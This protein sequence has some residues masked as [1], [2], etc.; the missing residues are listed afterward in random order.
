MECV[1]YEQGKKDIHGNPLKGIGIAVPKA[2][3]TLA[4]SIVSRMLA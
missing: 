1:I 3:I 2:A 4:Q